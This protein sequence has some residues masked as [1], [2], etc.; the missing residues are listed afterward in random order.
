[1]GRLWIISGRSSGTRPA[2]AINSSA[3]SPRS[4]AIRWTR[5]A[6]GGSTFSFHL[7]QVRWAHVDQLGEFPQAEALAQ[8]LL[9][10]SHPVLD[11]QA[12]QAAIAARK[13]EE[14]VHGSGS[15][16]GQ[17]TEDGR[18]PRRAY[19]RSFRGSGLVGIGQTVAQDRDDAVVYVS[20][21]STA[22]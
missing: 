10:E 1:M 17:A 2:R 6:V 15:R 4:S 14:G 13:T 18:D 22:R 16:G 7:G 8:P 21:P 19:F 5:S 11:L 9:A 12:G 20:V 3:F